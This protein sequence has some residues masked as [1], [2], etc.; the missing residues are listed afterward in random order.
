MLAGRHRVH[1]CMHMHACHNTSNHDL[2]G[3][4]LPTAD[5]GVAGVQYVKQNNTNPSD[6]M[7]LGVKLP[8]QR[9]LHPVREVLLQEAAAAAGLPASAVN[10]PAGG[11]LLCGNSLFHLSPPDDAPD[12]LAVY[13]A[14]DFLP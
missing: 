1:A 2:C 7:A 14:T 13:P 3:A 12:E 4:G 6:V 10:S 5:C 9:V 8:M 11:S